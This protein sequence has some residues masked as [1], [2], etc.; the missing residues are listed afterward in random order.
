VLPASRK[1]LLFDCNSLALRRLC[2]H[3]ATEGASSWNF[4]ALAE[5]GSPGKIA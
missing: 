2:L 4:T 1:S 3:R 5:V